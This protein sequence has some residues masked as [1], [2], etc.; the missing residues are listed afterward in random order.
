MRLPW[1]CGCRSRSRGAQEA[2]WLAST[3]REKAEGQA[4]EAAEAAAAAKSLAR[5]QVTARRL[6]ITRGTVLT[7]RDSAGM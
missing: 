3:A 5:E 4:V 2:E 7:A 6:A 1:R